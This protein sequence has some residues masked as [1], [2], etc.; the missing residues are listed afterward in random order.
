MTL[1]AQD[2]PP[3]LEI[4]LF[5]PAKLTGSN[6]C[7]ESRTRSCSDICV[8]IP[9]A[10]NYRCLCPDSRELTADNHTCRDKLNYTAPSPCRGDSFEC[11]NGLC[12]SQKWVC[13]GDPDCSDGSDESFDRCANKSCPEGHFKCHSTG[14]CISPRWV[15]DGEK[16][17]SDGED[18]NTDICA[19]KTCMA[20]HFLCNSGLCIPDIWRC[21]SDNDC[22]DGSDEMGDCS[23]TSCV[24]AV[25]FTC[26]NGR[27]VSLEWKC[28]GED[29][30]GDNSDESGCTPVD[31]C[32]FP[33]ETACGNGSTTCIMPG[34]RCDG[35]NDC[36]DGSDEAGCG[37]IT[38]PQNMLRCGTT[39]P[40]S[41]LSM[42]KC[43]GEAE[44]PDAWDETNCSCTVNDSVKQVRCLTKSYLYDCVNRCDGVEDCLDNSDENY[45]AV[46]G[47][48]VNAGCSHTCYENFTLNDGYICQCPKGME[49][50]SDHKTCRYIPFCTKQGQCSQICH[51]HRS[52]YECSCY[53]DWHLNPYD[54]TAW[55]CV[56]DRPEPPPFVIFSNLHALRYFPLNLTLESSRLKS[57]HLVNDMKWISGALDFHYRKRKLFY[58]DVAD[59][60]IT[61]ID[62]T[63]N[64]HDHSLQSSNSTVV[65]S[66]GLGTPEGIAVDWLADR[67]YFAD[68]TLDQIEVVQLDGQHRCV[69][70]A[71]GLSNPRALAVD[72]RYGLI[73]WTDWEEEN[74]RIERSTTAGEE[75]EVIWDAL[76]NGGGWPNALTIDYLQNRIYWADAKSDVIYSSRYDMS[77][78]VTV[79]WQ[80]DWLTHPYAITVFA[81]NLIWT[82]WGTTVIASAHKWPNRNSSV[83][84]LSLS[85]PFDIKVY[86]ESRQPLTK[87]ASSTEALENPCAN[88]ACEGLCV[89]SPLRIQTQSPPE[90]SYKCLCPHMLKLAAD[91][92][93][94]EHID[95]F[96]VYARHDEIRG[97]RVENLN[98]SATYALST[99]LVKNVTRLAVHASRD[100]IYWS[101]SVLREIKRAN[102]DGSSVE[103]VIE[104]DLESP[105]VVGLVVDW[106]RDLIFW[107]SYDAVMHNGRSVNRGKLSVTSLDG[108]YKVRLDNRTTGSAWSAL[109]RPRALTSDL[110]NGILYFAADDGIHKIAMD[111]SG[112]QRIIASNKVNDLKFCNGSL[113][114]TINNNL[115]RI[116]PGS[117]KQY[118]CHDDLEV[119]GTKLSI[120][121]HYMWLYDPTTNAIY[122]LLRKGSKWTR[123]LARGQVR[124]LRDIAMFDSSAQILTPALVANLPC[125]NNNG[126][127]EQICLPSPSNNRDVI[128]KCSVGFQPVK[129]NATACEA[130]Q[131]FL[132]YTNSHVLTG[133]D[134]HGGQ[135]ET[136]VP[137]TTQLLPTG[138]DFYARNNTIVW[139]DTAA[140]LIKAASRDA[141]SQW[142]VYSPYVDHKDT[143]GRQTGERFEGVAV[144]W[145]AKNV[146]WTDPG[147]DLIKV[148][149]LNGSFP[150]TIYKGGEKVRAIAVHPTR[151]LLF[152]TD[153]GSEASVIR[154]R[155]DGSQS[156]QVVTGLGWPNGL[157]IDYEHDKVFWCDA[158]TDL[159]QSSDLNG[160]NI[161]TVVTTTQRRAYGL[162][163]LNG[164]LY[165]TDS[166]YLDGSISSYDI[167]GSTGQLLRR[168]LSNHLKDIVAYSP[169]R[170]RGTNVCGI[171]NGGCEQLCFYLGDENRKCACAYGRL[172]D[173]NMT[174][175]AYDRY[176][177]YSFRTVIRSIDVYDPTNLNEP[178]PLIE[179]PKVMQSVVAMAMDYGGKR[180]F[181]S[182]MVKGNIYSIN[183]KERGR[184]TPNRKPVAKDVGTVEGLTY[185]RGYDALFWTSYTD[186]T[187]VRMFL[188]HPNAT[189]PNIIVMKQSEDD[190]LRALVIYECSQQ[191]YVFWTNWNKKSPGLWR[192]H[193]DGGDPQAIIV[194]R[195][196]TPNALTIDIVVRQLY[197]ADA[198][199]D[200][201]E[202]CDFNGRNRKIILSRGLEHAFSIAVL[203]K[204]LYWSDWQ[205]EKVMRAIKW[206][207]EE[208]EVM[209]NLTYINLLGVLAVYNDSCVP[210]PCDNFRC[211][212][213]CVVLDDGKAS[214]LCPNGE[215]AHLCQGEELS[216]GKNGFNCS[217][218]APTGGDKQEC[219]PYS[220]T[221]DGT[222]HCDDSADEDPL[223]CERR[224]CRDNYWMCGN[225]R[226]ILN[227]LVCNEIDDCGDGSDESKDVDCPSP[228]TTCLAGMYACGN[229]HCIPTSWKCDGE[230]DCGD[231]SD[232][233]C[234]ATCPDNSFQCLSDGICILSS[235][236][237]DYDID[238]ADGSDE[239]DC[240]GRCRVG[241]MSCAA[242][243][244]CIPLR[245][246]CDGQNDCVD[247]SDERSCD[248]AG[249]CLGGL[250]RCETSGKC[251]NMEWKCDRDDDCD[252]GSDE[253][254]CEYPP[255]NATEFKCTDG[256]C[257]PF[258]WHCDGDRDCADGSDE[259]NCSSTTCD[260]KSQI[261]C[262]AGLCLP[263]N[264]TC[265][266]K[267]D[268]PNGI[269][270]RGCNKDDCKDQSVCEQI[271]IE[272][273]YR[274]E[275]ACRKGYKLSDDE[276]H[277]TD[278]DE[279]TDPASNPPCSQVCTN[280]AGAFICSCAKGYFKDPHDSTHCKAGRRSGLG[281]IM[282]SNGKFIGRVDLETTHNSSRNLHLFDPVAFDVDFF[283]QRL[284]WSD[285]VRGHS[286]IKRA[287]LNQP[288]LTLANDIMSH[289]DTVVN[290][291]IR[292]VQ[293][294]AFDWYAD[295][296]YWTD[297]GTAKIEVAKSN[298]LFQK[299]L[300]SKGLDLPKA[301]ALDPEN[302]YMY[303]S[304]VGE[305]P[306]IGRAGMDGSNR[307]I[308]IDKTIFR[309]FAY[310]GSLTIDYPSAKLFWSDT[311]K[312]F[313]AF[314]NLDGAHP[315][316]VVE[317]AVSSQFASMFGAI[318]VFEDLVY[319]YDP[320]NATVVST[321]KFN[322][323]SLSKPPI[324]LTNIPYKITDLK[325]I[326]P[327]RQPAW[328]VSHRI[329]PCGGD[330]GC[331]DLCLIAPRGGHRCE[332]PN[333]F[334]LGAD[335]YSCIS[336]CS[337]SEFMCATDKCI[338][339]WW[340]CD[341]VND[342]ADN[343]DELPSLNCTEF[344]CTPGQFQCHNSTEAMHDC[345]NPTGL[346]DGI[347]ECK[348]GS[349]EINCDKHV[350]LRNQFKCSHSSPPICIPDLFVCDGSVQCAN[351]EDEENCG[352]VTCP[353]D[354][355]TCDSDQEGDLSP[356]CIPNSWVCDGAEECVNGDDEKKC[357]PKTCKEDEF[358]CVNHNSCILKAWKC[359]GEMD[360]ND[361][362]DEG[363]DI[364][365]TPACTEF[366][367][368]NGQCVSKKWRCDFDNDCGD[369]S[370]ETDC[371]QKECQDNHFLCT[372]KS[373]CILSEF[374]CDGTPDC[375]DKSDEANC[376]ATRCSAAEFACKDHHLCIPLENR[377]D[378]IINCMDGSDETECK[379][380]SIFQCP[381]H[382][383]RCED[384]TCIPLLWK[385][386][387]HFDCPD[388]SDEGPVCNQFVCLADRP[389]RCP[390]FNVCLP[391]T[392]ICDGNNDC[393][394]D[395]SDE[396]QPNCKGTQPDLGH[397]SDGST[398]VLW[399]KQTNSMVVKQTDG[400]RD[401]TEGYMCGDGTC[402]SLTTLC[403]GVQTCPD[404]R[405]ELFCLTG[406]C[407]AEH[408]C[409]HKIK[410]EC[411][412]LPRVASGGRYRSICKCKEGFELDSDLHCRDI[413]ECKT[414]HPCSQKCTNVIGSFHCSC[415]DGWTNYYHTF[416]RMS[417]S[418][419]QTA[420]L[421]TT[422]GVPTSIHIFA[423]LEA[424]KVTRQSVV[425]F[426]S[427]GIE[428]TRMTPSVVDDTIY[429]IDSKHRGIYSW[430]GK[431]PTLLLRLPAKHRPSGLDFDWVGSNLY[432]SDL[433][434]R[435]VHIMPIQKSQTSK[436][437]LEHFAI[438][439]S[440]NSMI[441]WPLDVALSIQTGFMFVADGGTD[442][443]KPSILRLPMN[444]QRGANHITIRS[445]N[446]QWP[447][448]VVVD[449]PASRIYW[450]DS[451]SRSIWS[452]DFDGTGQVLV[453]QFDIHIWPKTIA[454]FGDYI[455]ATTSLTFRVL[456]I[457]KLA[458][459]LPS[460]A[461]QRLSKSHQTV[462]FLFNSG[463]KRVAPFAQ[464]SRLE[465]VDY[466]LGNPPAIAIADGV[467]QTSIAMQLSKKS[468]RCT[469]CN[470]NLTTLCL[471]DGESYSCRCPQVTSSGRA[472]MLHCACVGVTCTDG[473]TCVA[474]KCGCPSGK[475]CHVTGEAAGASPVA[476]VVIV[477]VLFILIVGVVLWFVYRKKTKGLGFRHFMSP[478]RNEVENMR[479]SEL[480]ASEVT[481]LSGESTKLNNGD[482][483]SDS[484][485]LLHLD[486]GY[487]DE[488]VTEIEASDDDQ[489]A[490]GDR[491]TLGY[492]RI[493]FE[494]GTTERSSEHA[495]LLTDDPM[496][497]PPEGVTPDDEPLTS[498]DETPYEVPSL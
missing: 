284:Y 378:G 342:C 295:N 474:G 238:C 434:T 89:I 448:S 174:C 91:G 354:H 246:S 196:S 249:T 146:Y 358:A 22:H 267:P 87:T 235:Y 460:S 106:M 245:W 420:R 431:H 48:C 163:Y 322:R 80:I 1:V 37:N 343:S 276:S 367:C 71:G 197:W 16:D 192:A 243:D 408:N 217:V 287:D 496:T 247:G 107:T 170:Q 285:V 497:E 12:I 334:Y 231:G 147:M 135:T 242:N 321:D 349:D 194:T 211:K 275:C 425:Q 104:T 176:I 109:R 66:G 153:W 488:V 64:T 432:W 49:L 366:L 114:A 347:R 324:V 239:A 436:R 452:S 103:T 326:H 132:L 86:H 485:G 233:R 165:W 112:L 225:G 490:N 311:K 248:D 15:C 237:C 202:S 221:C 404:G 226:C 469:R 426:N 458:H 475:T 388:G 406:E 53:P 127:C 481:S 472:K 325:V 189:A 470:S 36:P 416:C 462:P 438:Y 314:C 433:G 134:I 435:S 173:D 223:Y 77:D 254:N 5:D 84:E 219:I 68:S 126:G 351:H 294:I 464:L 281:E 144:D 69:V 35:D 289:S 13:D 333:N 478:S 283:K 373:K 252:D 140:S 407:T 451:K 265:N 57:E 414:L 261:Q 376:T 62:L 133:V 387:G 384:N 415:D 155:L 94:C 468:G 32:T 118:W 296:I 329:K 229:G 74:P 341:G 290:V 121:A 213:Q 359:D 353:A 88:H 453:R 300:I 6:Q 117:C 124:E 399:R 90:L 320:H 102:V 258:K 368:N 41:L 83:L 390:T 113:Y 250:F 100:E 417:R 181:Y 412:M 495:L 50:N 150:Y 236:K 282:F 374:R 259:R 385:C 332:C 356:D 21:D 199:L 280:I 186:K 128:C 205:R 40:C 175:Q 164:I 338:P 357:P 493:Y 63:Y 148:I 60:T 286:V 335:K 99:P 222:H 403:D 136:L 263:L 241:F 419:Q 264:V 277:C 427:S 17:C 428:V 456:R 272:K 255:C 498:N 318:A 487:E 405:D 400:A 3:M 310:P 19:S 160:N 207:G 304:D 93:S 411:S 345:I 139:I 101:D 348:D 344:F 319:W 440:E 266:D 447:N 206:T 270:E 184:S 230:D 413:D 185:H 167:V 401:I 169:D 38:C 25:Y 116:Y 391:L 298:G 380:S 303:W 11:S 364:C 461:T 55:E 79:V 402:A 466:G 159:I 209:R 72:P 20:G 45:C 200:K 123:K 98:Y 177:L 269:D 305:K 251:I 381:S 201:I 70:V 313:I 141:K 323:T 293:G 327:L 455:F 424:V 418:P 143:D 340:K 122:E 274:Y 51:Q 439:N 288:Y 18:E 299:T 292:N 130:I 429:W 257:V 441:N 361:G 215:V 437:P 480:N 355:Y 129:S 423:P 240:D 137:I 108:R 379:V 489:T 396:N 256:K 397:S 476:P 465:W 24:S 457:H 389:F 483:T 482:A 138:V 151:G 142:I 446:M 444:G 187:V 234:N 92:R 463:P 410:G 244:H 369:N 449:E 484:N 4:V 279:C 422:S 220:L 29:D 445:K 330:S 393:L 350:C 105:N 157:T 309:A 224:S 479:Y 210:N 161:K 262:Q 491:V 312:G 328:D 188:S 477:T 59:D 317:S 331:H 10:P 58:T 370:D 382:M 119:Q 81:H 149:R 23:Y 377:C 125:R 308:V 78:H 46:E 253:M 268:C 178:F 26:D 208:V 162:T 56:F 443:I 273:V 193:L 302:G 494:S 228:K 111:G 52:T 2:N 42:W 383:F 214:C 172:S 232:E 271:C 31:S 316:I 131:D 336:N 75:R 360:C 467:P 218:T 486:N 76:R 85:Q 120:Q 54:V 392:K 39:G 454:L 95:A 61:S 371:P 65:I 337:F 409:T 33:H 278:L 158:K 442:V 168:R 363:P 473:E 291:T 191:N 212:H 82:D 96:L 180:I 395:S 115:N 156:T 260:R 8:P 297:M 166:Q 386:D 67:I 459:T 27:C 216:C 179:N 365:S 450:V 430:N 110:S 352:P 394:G 375:D 14:L 43:D 227:K 152:A 9:E 306:Y 301:I 195:I 339:F 145:I 492:D 421:I 34:W 30:C 47:T 190:S 204:H 362:S 97:V 398:C 73:F 198:T 315:K 471:N 182:D 28:D 372:D 346:C 171:N 203:G 183:M 7:S 307:S 154:M 44:C